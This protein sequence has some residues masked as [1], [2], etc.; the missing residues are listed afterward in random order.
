MH[1]WIVSHWLFA[2][3]W[4]CVQIWFPAL[5][6]SS[7]IFWYTVTC[8]ILLHVFC[9]KGSLAWAKVFNLRPNLT[10]SFPI[11]WVEKV[12][13]KDIWLAF[14]HICCAPLV[15]CPYVAP[16]KG[17]GLLAPLPLSWGTPGLRSWPW[18]VREG[19]W[20]HQGMHEFGGGCWWPPQGSGHVLLPAAHGTLPMVHCPCSA[21]IE[22]R[23]S[24]SLL[25]FLCWIAV[26]LACKDK[27]STSDFYP[28][29]HIKIC[30]GTL[31]EALEGPNNMEPIT[32]ETYDTYNVASE[33]FFIS[34]PKQLH[35][36]I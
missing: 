27:A 1:H 13:L 21:Q 26:V 16:N 29:W 32:L 22:A 4:L 14:W 11:D 19:P 36:H 5:C 7:L 6:L 18:T 2:I 3:D 23:A 24:Y 15:C 28:V 33:V 12:L 35:Q 30:W 9:F 25:D 8:Y 34:C 17:L 10:V 20:G 31:L